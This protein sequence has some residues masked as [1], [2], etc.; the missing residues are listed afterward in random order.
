MSGYVRLVH[1]RK[2]FSGYVRL[3]QDIQVKCC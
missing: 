3:G 1:I 2:V